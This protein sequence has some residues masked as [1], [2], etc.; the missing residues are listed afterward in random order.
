MNLTILFKLQTKGHLGFHKWMHISAVLKEENEEPAYWQS[1]YYLWNT[2][3]LLHKADFVMSCCFPVF[4]CSWP[5]RI[6]CTVFL[7]SSLSMRSWRRSRPWWGTRAS[8]SWW[9]PWTQS[10][11]GSSR[12]FSKASESLLHLS[13]PYTNIFAKCFPPPPFFK[14]TGKAND[15]PEVW[16]P[17]P[18]QAL[19]MLCLMYI[20]S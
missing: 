3:C 4:P 20:Q 9:K 6:Q 8:G 14:C 16:T 18:L 13:L 19:P 12:N 1:L 15:L 10:S 11:S 7:C 5:S 17:K 2:C